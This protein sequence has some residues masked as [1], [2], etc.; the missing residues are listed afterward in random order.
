MMRWML[1]LVMQV[2]LR[3][4]VL[5]QGRDLFLIVILL[6]NLLQHLVKAFLLLVHVIVVMM[7]MMQ[8]PCGGRILSAT[9]RSGHTARLFA[10]GLLL[11]F[12]ARLS[13][14]SLHLLQFFIL[15]MLEAIVILV[16]TLI[17]GSVYFG[18]RVM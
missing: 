6:L 2:M 11:L 15:Q 14:R 18:W 8:M 7:V 17:Y 16:R 9:L 10:L 13:I 4:I 12:I 1:R 3:L 5:E